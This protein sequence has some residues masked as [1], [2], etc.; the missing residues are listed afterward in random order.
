MQAERIFRY[1]HTASSYKG[2]FHVYTKTIHGGVRMNFNLH[3]K[4]ALVSGCSQGLGYE[5]VKI[6]AAQGADIFGVSIGDD[7]ELKKE[8][9]AMGRQYHSLT[10]SLTTPD[11]IHTLLKEVLAAYGR[12]DILLNFAAILKKADTL[13]LT[14]HDF[15]NAM[16]IN[17]TASFFLSQ[18]V[19]KQFKKQ[20]QGGKIINA[21]GI[22]PFDTNEYCAY[23]TSKGALEAM[24]KYL[25]YEFADENIQVNAI[26]FG[27]M[28]AGARLQQGDGQ[29]DDTSILHRIPA[30][31]WGTKDDIA[32]IVLLL[33]SSSSD[34]ITGSCIPVDGGYSIR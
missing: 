20:G 34:Y 5:C 21:S 18:V 17:V 12:I 22:L 28:A 9:E 15:N 4:I 14:K 27:F 2:K 8:V 23:Y 19:I 31:R 25:A 16:D 10:I 3:G 6:L 24:T 11:A 1:Q 33:A 7:S 13:T 26:A 30:G 32:G 29:I